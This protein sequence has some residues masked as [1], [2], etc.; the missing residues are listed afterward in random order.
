MKFAI[1][2]VLYSILTILLIGGLTGWCITRGS[3][4]QSETPSIYEKVVD[5][6]ATGSKEAKAKLEDLRNFLR[7]QDKMPEETEETHVNRTTNVGETQVYVKG[8]TPFY[9]K[10]YNNPNIVDLDSLNKYVESRM[11]VLKKL[12][13]QSPNRTI[14]V[15]ISPAEEITLTEFWRLRDKYGLDVNVLYLD[16]LVDGE[17]TA[18]VCA[19]DE[20]IEG[21]KSR[22][23][24]FSKNGEDVE[25]QLKKVYSSTPSP[26]GQSTARPDPL[27]ISYRIQHIRGKIPAE[28]AL[29]FEGEPPILLV[30]PATD[31]KDAFVNKAADI[32]VVDMPHLYVTKRNILGKAP[33]SPKE[34]LPQK[35]SGDYH[36]KVVAP[37]VPRLPRE[38]R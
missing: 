21:K 17:W 19:S 9:L 32:Y 13:T 34:T 38:V 18:T 27:S 24:D 6:A 20:D 29:S 25:T 5:L 1:K 22:V 4:A 14:S 28:K 30:D 12:A 8:I 36:G 23:F 33:T 26:P 10:I 37:E 7:R 15:D 11:R 16:L 2:K 31:L 35:K 3:T